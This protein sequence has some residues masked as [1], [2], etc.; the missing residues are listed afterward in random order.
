[1][2]VLNHN[3]SNKNIE[4]SILTA[5]VQI[6]NEMNGLVKGLRM[7]RDRFSDNNIHKMGLRLI[8]S[9]TKDGI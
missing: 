6:L 7:V 8:S 5:L 9:R 3:T 4:S 1:M 2:S